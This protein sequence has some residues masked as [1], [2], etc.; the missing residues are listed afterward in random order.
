MSI[1]SFFPSVFDSPLTNGYYLEIEHMTSIHFLDPVKFNAIRTMMSE[2]IAYNVFTDPST[3]KLEIQL[4]Q[5]VL[6][7]C[8]GGADGSFSC[9]V[10]QDISKG[11]VRNEFAVHSFATGIGNSDNDR[12]RD[13]ITGN[14]LGVSGFSEDLAA[15]M[16]SLVRSKYSIDDRV[17]KAWYINPGYKWTSPAGKKP[18]PK[19]I[20]E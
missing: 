17:N 2:G 6:D 11:V 8:T 9:A 10:R 7:A 12:T 4:S 16:T 1:N 5:Q 20:N 15:N 18:I 19:Q 13:W 14:L 3:G